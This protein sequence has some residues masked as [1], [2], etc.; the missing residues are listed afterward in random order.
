MSPYDS[1]NDVLNTVRT[2]MNDALPTLYPISGKVLGNTQPFMQQVTNTGWRKFQNHLSNLGY[3]KL[4]GKA[5]ITGLP[6]CGNQQDPA[7]ESYINWFN[8][9]DGVNLFESPVLPDDLISPLTL[10]E[11]V[12]G[13]NAQFVPMTLALDGIPS[14][15][16]QNYNRVWE[17]RDDAI[18]FPGSMSVMDIQVQYVRRLPDFAD[19]G[20]SRWFTQPVQIA[21]ALDAFAWFICSEIVNDT[22]DVQ[23]AFLLLGQNA[24]NQIMN[25]D[26][27]LK[28]RVNV[29][30][31]PRSGG[32]GSRGA[33]G[34]V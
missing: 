16:K 14:Y 5:I 13:Q 3:Q 22:P 4:K 34:Y 7:T 6:L 18:Y 12:S 23:Q 26:I 33:Y 20:G 24:A 15:V 21:N 11:R 30:R 19:V 25:R 27:K 29:R 28:Q 1:V 8:F 17:W 2:R 10:S 9:F 31:Q 32:R